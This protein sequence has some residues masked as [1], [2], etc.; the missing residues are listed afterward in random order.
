MMSCA[1][2]KDMRPA[3]NSVIFHPGMTSSG[4]PSGTHGRPMPMREKQ[5]KPKTST[6]RC[7]VVTSTRGHRD[8]SGE[9]GLTTY[10]NISTYMWGHTHTDIYIY[11]DISDNWW[12][13][14]DWVILSNILGIITDEL[15]NRFLSNQYRRYGF[16]TLLIWSIQWHAKIRLTDRFW[17]LHINPNWSICSDFS[18]K[19][20]C[21]KDWC[22]RC[23]RAIDLGAQIAPNMK[24]FGKLMEAAAK[25]GQVQTATLGFGFSAGF[26]WLRLRHE[27][28][29][30]PK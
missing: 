12:L 28:F 1:T 15:G 18:A 16:E 21:G 27:E 26:G 11:Y 10:Y 5:R 23:H 20:S 8:D 13:V 2:W 4:D 9:H 17:Q 25:K 19:K 3:E 30:G 6:T 7:W 14:D 29:Q 24:T 22:A